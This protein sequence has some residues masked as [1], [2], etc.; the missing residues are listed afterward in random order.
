MQK[1]VGS[2]EEAALSGRG[3]YC[4]RPQYAHLGVDIVTWRPDQRKKLVQHF[5]ESSLLPDG[6][7]T[8]TKSSNEQITSPNHPAATTC[9]ISISIQSPS[10]QGSVGVASPRPSTSVEHATHPSISSSESGIT[11]L[12]NILL[13]AMWDKAEKL[14]NEDRGLQPAAS[15]DLNAWS[16]Q[17]A[18][19]AVPHFVTSKEG[20]QYLCNTYCTQWVSSKICSHSM[21]VA[22]SGWEVGC[23]SSVVYLN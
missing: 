10:K 5:D 16:V 13:Q 20:G 23:I 2:K 9:Y 11:S 15:S 17:S 21:A 12:H 14:L 18:S 1:F 7:K 3:F 8:Q 22:E 19:S 6:S 4:L